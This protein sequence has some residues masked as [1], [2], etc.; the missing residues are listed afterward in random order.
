MAV[1][2]L[3]PVFTARPFALKCILMALQMWV[4]VYNGA[5]DFAQVFFSFVQQDVFVE[6]SS[7]LLLI[8][9]LFLKRNRVKVVKHFGVKVTLDVLEF[10]QG[11]P[12]ISIGFAN[13]NEMLT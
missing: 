1:L 5:E 4:V 11:P 2:I 10:F 7:I 3:L 13:S 12:C 8:F 9:F 6:L